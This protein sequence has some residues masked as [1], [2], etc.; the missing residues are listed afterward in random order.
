[1][2]LKVGEEILWKITTIKFRDTVYWH[3]FEGGNNDDEKEN[4]SGGKKERIRK[5]K[6]NKKSAQMV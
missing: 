6:Y 4:I 1:M 2:E 5:E 3:E